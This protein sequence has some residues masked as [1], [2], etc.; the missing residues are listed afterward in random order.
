MGS[1]L[2]FPSSRVLLFDYPKVDLNPGVLLSL[3]FSGWEGS[4]TQID[5]TEKKRWYPSSNLS[6]GGPSCFLTPVSCRGPW[7]QKPKGGYPCASSDSCGVVELWDPR[8]PEGLFC[9]ASLHSPFHHPK[10]GCGEV[11][12]LSPTTRLQPVWERTKII[13]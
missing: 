7:V 2:R 6:T 5:K 3:P 9:P 8:S 13:C 1:L 12:A 11:K 10:R 4:P